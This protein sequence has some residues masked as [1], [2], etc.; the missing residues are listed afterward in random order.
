MKEWIR[1]LQDGFEIMVRIVTKNG[2]V[3]KFAVV[4]MHDGEDITRFDNAHGV[5]HRDVLGRKNAFIRKEW[6]ESMDTSEAFQYAIND[7]SQN[8]HRYLAYYDAH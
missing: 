7:L 5:A 2:K 8:C 4:L 6:Y 1:Y 3:E